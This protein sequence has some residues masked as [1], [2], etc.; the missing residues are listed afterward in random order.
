MGTLLRRCV[1][2]RTAIV[3]LFGVVHMPRG[4]GAVSGVVSGIVRHFRPILYNGDIRIDNRLVCE[5]LAVFPYARYNVEFCV[6]FPFF[7]IE[8][9]VDAKCMCKNVTLNTRELP[10]VAAA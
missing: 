1:E 9:R 5:K 7:K 10:P 2:V 4:E 6:K 3:M 8:V